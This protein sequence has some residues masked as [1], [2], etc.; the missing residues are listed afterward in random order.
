[1][2]FPLLASAGSERSRHVHVSLFGRLGC[3]RCNVSG[4]L[5]GPSCRTSVQ[6]VRADPRHWSGDVGQACSL[7]KGLG[8]AD[9][10]SRN[11]ASFRHRLC[12]QGL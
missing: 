12:H 6:P 1:M 4:G 10:A 8:S 3:P 9:G 2:V 7:R 11:P 5:N